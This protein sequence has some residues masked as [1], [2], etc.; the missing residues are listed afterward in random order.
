MQRL[1][2][3]VAVLTTSCASLAFAHHH[4]TA[5]Y[6]K[7]RQA[8]FIDRY[9]ADD[10]DRV[11]SVEFEQARRGR[12]DLT[13]EDESGKVS[14]EEYVY[15]WEDRLDLGL[16]RDR[17]LAVTQT[18]RRFAALDENDDAG[19]TWSEYDASGRRM[20]SAHDSDKND[21][22]NGADTKRD[23]IMYNPR[24]TLTEDQQEAEQAR[25]IRRANRM[26]RMPSTHTLKGMLTKYDSDGDEV[27][28]WREFNLARKEDFARSDVDQNGSVD[29][30]EYVIEFEDRLDARISETRA[31]SV[32]QARRRFKALDDDADG[33]MTF[34]EYQKSGHGMFKRWDS[35]D[36]GYVSRDD[37]LPKPRE[38]R[39]EQEKD[40]GSTN[41]AV[42][43]ATN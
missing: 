12:F 4:E 42:N 41:T 27:L 38:Q 35:G 37:A 5:Q 7:M 16:A 15:E 33:A 20:F 32:K 6:M 25:L 13:D 24:K 8:Q 30:E 10:D 1:L 43:A 40:G 22:I 18:F 19:V 21:E 36:D 9:D 39:A 2:L 14:S 34:A 3:S 11:S 29:E 23:N 17:K 26:L 31:G 28:S